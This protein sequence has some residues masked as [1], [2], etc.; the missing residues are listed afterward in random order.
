M[1]DDCIRGLLLLFRIT[2][3]LPSVCS[4]CGI[5]NPAA[6]SLFIKTES[7]RVSDTKSLAKVAKFLSPSFELKLAKRP[8]YKEERESLVKRRGK[9]SLN[10][11]LLLLG[12]KNGFFQ[13]L[14]LNI[15]L[16]FFAISPNVNLVS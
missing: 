11:L 1:T 8:S 12:E 6:I 13:V 7:N 14:N 5:D 3:Q 4:I 2:K 15:S 9:F 10:L 16:P